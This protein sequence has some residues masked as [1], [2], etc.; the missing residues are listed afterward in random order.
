MFQGI[1]FDKN[2]NV[3][4]TTK[5]HLLLNFAYEQG[6]QHELSEIL[7]RTYFQEGKDINSD[8]ILEQCAAEAGIEPNVVEMVQHDPKTIG[9]YEEEIKESIQKGVYIKIM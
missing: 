8:S 1:S 4:R 7:F 5:A 9:H 3:V 6:K 2:R